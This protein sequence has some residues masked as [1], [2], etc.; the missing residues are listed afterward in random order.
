M[1]Y[2]DREAQAVQ[3]FATRG[4]LER[5]E[6][7]T[8]EREEYELYIEMGSVIFAGVDY[9]AILREAE[10]G[11]DVLVWDGGNNDFPFFHSDLH[12]VLVDALRADQVTTHHP[13]EAVARMADVAIVN[14]IDAAPADAVER[15][16]RSLRR[17]NPRARILRA[18]SPVQLD[19][20]D[21]VAGRRVLVV[22]DG[23]TTTHGGMAYG[24]GYVAAIAAGAG[25]IV[26][27]RA[28]AVPEIAAVFERFPHLGNVL[29]AMGY[30]ARQI[31]ALRRTIDASDADVVV[32]GSPIDL[33]ALLD[34]A[35]PVVRA[36][37]HYE[38]ADSP[39]LAGVL[40]EFLA[41]WSG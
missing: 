27:P 19:D 23:P 20:P 13:G 15:A 32:S 35:K 18:A 40:D 12:V 4:G 10:K 5:H 34:V 8:E 9:A 30:G 2:G 24:A 25:E 26:D 31:D 17:V 11:A 22:E 3:R 28:A 6:C 41:G 36:R 7:T 14:K 39:G 21:A 37:Y 29:P 38:D 1:P 16:I 33:E